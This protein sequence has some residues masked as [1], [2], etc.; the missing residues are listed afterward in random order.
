MFV[1]T[2]SRFS[3]ILGSSIS[4]ARG[5]TSQEGSTRGDHSLTVGGGGYSINDRAVPVSSAETKT[6]AE[7]GV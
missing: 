4:P 5:G 6:C 1:D 3:N 7:N 2:V